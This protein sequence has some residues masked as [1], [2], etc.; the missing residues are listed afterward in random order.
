M[1]QS[2]ILGF[3]LPPSHLRAFVD[4]MAPVNEAITTAESS[5]KYAWTAEAKDA[6][7]QIALK[8]TNTPKAY[9]YTHPDR[10]LDDSHS[11]LQLGDGDPLAVCAGIISVPVADA[12]DITLDMIHSKAPARYV[13]VAMYCQKLNK[14]HQKWGMH[15]IETFAHVVCHRKSCKFV[16]ELMAKF[17]CIPPVKG[18]SGE[19][20]GGATTAKLKSASDDTTALGT[21]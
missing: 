4:L 9:I 5:G 1:T 16:N 19:I 15:E 21:I 10:V 6:Q 14:R 3:D 8:M 13:L 2:G 12:A 7:A 17:T 11:L 20:N 18:S